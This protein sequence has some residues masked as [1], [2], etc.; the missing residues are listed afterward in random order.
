MHRTTKREKKSDD[1]ARRTRSR[2]SQ[3]GGGC[4]AASSSNTRLPG[5]ILALPH[6]V[7]AIKQF[8]MTPEKAIIEAARLGQEER[9]DQLLT[10]YVCRVPYALVAAAAYGHLN[11]VEC[12]Y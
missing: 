3:Q 7:T 5:E 11:C 1:E 4:L 9:L 12:C 2:L 10:K 6:V 8:L